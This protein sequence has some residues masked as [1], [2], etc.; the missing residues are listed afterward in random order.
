M[1]STL[2]ILSSNRVD[3]RFGLLRA[4]KRRALV[5]YITAGYPDIDQSL[6]LLR[7]LEAEGADVVEIGVPFSDPIA[8]GPVIQE[9]SQR[10]LA[11]G[12][13]LE[14][15]LDLVARA[16]LN[17][18]VVLFSYL[19][20][21]IAAGEDCLRRAA[22]CGVDGVLVTDLPVGADADRERWLGESDLAF[23]RLVA[24]TTPIERMREISSH[25]SGF[26]Y[27]ISRLGVTG[28]QETISADLA[29]T[30]ERLR[31]ATSLPICVGFGI[32]TAKQA[33]AV[34]QL[35]DGVVVGSALVQAA[36]RSITE[37]LLL[38]ASLRAALDSSVG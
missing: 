4:T 2:A 37:A 19:N 27:L 38:T 11:A 21:L 34:A 6:M 23:I 12:M 24:P 15:T 1:A 9:S 16:K 3:Q 8:D 28:I 7:G 31:R 5:C 35:A 22:R 17:I 10:A 14:K 13:T 20:P 32:S 30:V 25:G 18:P 36:G 33:T 26:V 29:P